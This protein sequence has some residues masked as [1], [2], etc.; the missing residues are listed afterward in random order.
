MS[1]GLRDLDTNAV[2]AIGGAADEAVGLGDLDTDVVL[3][4]GVADEA[5]FAAGLL[6]R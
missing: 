1:S 5:F 6:T 3:A 4:I 2:P